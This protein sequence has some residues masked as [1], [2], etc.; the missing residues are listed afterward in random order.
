MTQDYPD[1]KPL[2]LIIEDD[3]DATVIF[4]EALQAAGYTTEIIRDGQKALARLDT[5][6]PTL[7]AL[8]LHLPHVSG[9]TILRHIR[10]DTRLMDTSIM[11]LTADPAMADSL[12]DEADLVLLKP[13]GFRQLRDLATRLHPPDIVGQF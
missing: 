5:I 13:I 9:A 12:R 11:L 1:N 4:D 8:D 7:I 2:A 3:Y 6:T 10:A